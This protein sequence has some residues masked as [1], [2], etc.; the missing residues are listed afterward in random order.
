MLLDNQ[1]Q[2]AIAISILFILLIQG[3]ASKNTLYFDT[4]LQ[5]TLQAKQ[6]FPK[7]SGSQYVYCF[8]CLNSVKNDDT[9]AGESH[10]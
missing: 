2:Y 7:N 1:R 6:E 3:C 5:P 10:V 4:H 9:H 8:D